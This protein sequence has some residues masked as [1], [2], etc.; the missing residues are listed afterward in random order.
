[1]MF[2]FHK[3]ARTLCNILSNVPLHAALPKLYLQILVYF[4]VAW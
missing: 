2:S 4:V 1:L 3:L